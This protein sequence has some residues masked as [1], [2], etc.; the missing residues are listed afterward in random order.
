[1]RDTAILMYKVR[2]DQVQSQM[3]E[4]FQDVSVLHSRNT[5]SNSENN[6][7]LEGRNLEIGLKAISFAGPKI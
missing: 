1:M 3:S 2:S 5:R 7:Y 4:H 6:F